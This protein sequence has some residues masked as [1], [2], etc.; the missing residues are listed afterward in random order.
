MIIWYE[1]QEPAK[2]NMILICKNNSKAFPPTLFVNLEKFLT[3]AL[4]ADSAIMKRLQQAAKAPTR[5][6]KVPS[7]HPFSLRT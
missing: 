6:N 1:I 7:T 5:I 2:N 4:I 3:L